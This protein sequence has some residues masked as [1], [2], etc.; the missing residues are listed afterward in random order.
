MTTNVEGAQ[1]SVTRTAKVDNSKFDRM[2]RLV[3]KVLQ[4][5]IKNQFIDNFSL[6]AC[7]IC[8]AAHYACVE[9]FPMVLD[10]IIRMTPLSVSFNMKMLMVVVVLSNNKSDCIDVLVK[11][12]TERGENANRIIGKVLRFVQPFYDNILHHEFY[13]RK[14]LSLVRGVLE[15]EPWFDK[16]C[17]AAM[18]IGDSTTMRILA[19]ITV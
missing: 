1:V 4:I 17:I 5:V 8:S 13:V 15:D 18:D 2:S 10:H 11:H 19:E 7:R 3:N 6:K 9:D 16:F 12:A 14:L